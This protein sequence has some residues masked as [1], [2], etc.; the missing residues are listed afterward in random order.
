ME[1]EP[2]TKRVSTSRGACGKRIA[3]RLRRSRILPLIAIK[4]NGTAGKHVQMNIKHATSNYEL[5]SKP[6][7][8]WQALGSFMPI[9]FTC[10]HIQHQSFPTA[11]VGSRLDSVEAQKYDR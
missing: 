7:P 6:L 2:V 4:E 8:A 11:A 10:R 5:T 3:R 1:A 9:D